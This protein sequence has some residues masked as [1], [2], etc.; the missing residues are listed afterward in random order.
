MWGIIQVTDI[1]LAVCGH[2]CLAVRLI[3]WR[4]R[5]IN[6]NVTDVDEVRAA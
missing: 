2:F 6:Q 5:G 1:R 3:L 4:F